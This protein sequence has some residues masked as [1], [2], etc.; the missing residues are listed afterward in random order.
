MWAI[1]K[2]TGKHARWCDQQEIES[3]IEPKWTDCD[4]KCNLS[5]S[6]D[7]VMRFSTERH[8]LLSC[9][10]T[11]SMYML[12]SKWTYQRVACVFNTI[13]YDF[14]TLETRSVSMLDHEIEIITVSIYVIRC[15]CF[16]R[17]LFAVCFLLLLHFSSSVLILYQD[18]WHFIYF[19][20]QRTH[21]V[22]E[23][24]SKKKCRN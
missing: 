24:K 10:A 14:K 18:R 9:I 12:P 7:Q 16:S 2:C 13:D 23:R 22:N 4:W 17:V 5:F 6:S 19:N 1:R 20:N 15:V 21:A 8:R 3:K 11:H